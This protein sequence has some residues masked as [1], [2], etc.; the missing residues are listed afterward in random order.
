MEKLV[1][2]MGKFNLVVEKY[3]GVEFIVYFQDKKTDCITQDVVTIRRK[4]ENG[5][6]LQNAVECLVW[7]DDSNEDY[8][9]KFVIKQLLE[10]V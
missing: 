8:T 9:H 5:E 3:E 6:L 4:L 10:A 7:T 2:D 1:I